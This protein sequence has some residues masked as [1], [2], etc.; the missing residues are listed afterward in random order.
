MTSPT[1]LHP[2]PPL[3]VPDAVPECVGPAAE[4]GPEVYSDIEPA[5]VGF[6]LP[7]VL[8]PLLVPVV[9]AAQLTVVSKVLPHPSIFVLIDFWCHAVLRL[10][11]YHDFC[12]KNYEE[13]LC[14]TFGALP[15][16]AAAS[17][18]C[19]LYAPGFCPTYLP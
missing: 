17:T 5:A 4:P 16:G 1:T 14:P 6:S 11:L 7:F 3:L 19:C 10:R 13:S 12:A 8:T 15:F 9:R 18:Q 2:T